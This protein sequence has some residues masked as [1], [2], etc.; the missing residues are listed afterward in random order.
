MI[1]KSGLQE[2]R[3]VCQGLQPGSH[4]SGNECLRPEGLL[5]CCLGNHISSPLSSPG[6]SVSSARAHPVVLSSDL[7]PMQR[8][9]IFCML[10]VR[11]LTHKTDAVILPRPSPGAS[12]VLTGACRDLQGLTSGSWPPLPAPH[13]LLAPSQP[14]LSARHAPQGLF[15]G[16]VRDF[17]HNLSPESSL[18]SPPLPSPSFSPLSLLFPSLSSPTFLKKTFLSFYFCLCWVFTASQAFFL[19]ATSSG[20]SLIG[21]CRLL[22][23]L[24]SLVAEHGLRGPQAQ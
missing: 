14:L 4:S 11:L 6:A 7:T 1:C 16:C 18:P 13:P 8:L 9:L 20:C 10:S 3:R 21:V 2:H 17:P 22:I 19:V 5:F 15:T 24:A 12:Q 23:V